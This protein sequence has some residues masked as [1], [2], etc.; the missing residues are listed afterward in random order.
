MCGVILVPQRSEA[1]S[2]PA[3]L[4]ASNLQTCDETRPA[5]LSFDSQHHNNEKSHFGLI[6]DATP[7]P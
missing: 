2:M 4:L 3:S 6:A 7:S 1:G 5:Q